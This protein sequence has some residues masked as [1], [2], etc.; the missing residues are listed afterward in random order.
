MDLIKLQETLN[1][2]KQMIKELDLNLEPIIRNKKLHDLDIEYKKLCKQF[3]PAY[4]TGSSWYVGESLFDG[5]INDPFTNFV[6]MVGC[7][8]NRY[9]EIKK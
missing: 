7:I 6:F 2:S 4:L 3:S 8:A 1:K 5:K 9:N